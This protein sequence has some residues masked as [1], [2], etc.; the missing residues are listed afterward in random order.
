MDHTKKIILESIEY[1]EN[2]IKEYKAMLSKN[3]EIIDN[4]STSQKKRE[5]FEM[6]NEI[7]LREMENDQNRIKELIS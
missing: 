3:K 5:A 6:L 2:D 7:I 4:P 1:Y